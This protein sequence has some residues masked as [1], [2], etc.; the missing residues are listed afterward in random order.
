MSCK[1]QTQF[2]V[3]E[4]KI[5]EDTLKK[6]GYS[7]NKHSGTLQVTGHSGYGITVAENEI[8]YDSVDKSNVDT[9]KVEYSRALA[10]SMVEKE[11]ALYQMEETNNEII[12]TY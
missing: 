9:I 7:F 2:A 4:M 10:L 11:G 12:I 8:H 5:M 1:I 3:R 6:L